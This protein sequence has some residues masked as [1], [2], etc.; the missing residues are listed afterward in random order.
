ME[1]KAI[2]MNYR[3]VISENPYWQRNGVEIRDPDGFG[4]ILTMKKN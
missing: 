2:E 1:A 3:I 4:V